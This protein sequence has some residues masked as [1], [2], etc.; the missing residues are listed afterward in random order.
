[1]V[2]KSSIIQLKNLIVAQPEQAEERIRKLKD[3]AT[4]FIQSKEKKE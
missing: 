1:M 2:L 4:E 3:T